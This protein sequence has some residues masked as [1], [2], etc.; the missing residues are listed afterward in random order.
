MNVF[1]TEFYEESR[2]YLL[3][4][5]S[6]V[7]DNYRSSERQIHDK[8]TPK[9]DRTQIRLGNIQIEARIDKRAFNKLLPKQRIVFYFLIRLAEFEE[10][11]SYVQVE[12]RDSWKELLEK[13]LSGSDIVF[14][15]SNLH[16]YFL[17]EYFQSIY[18]SISKQR[19]FFSTLVGKNKEKKELSLLEKLSKDSFAFK[20]EI[21]VPKKPKKPQF[22]K[23]YRD[24]GS[25]GSELSRIRREERDDIYLRKSYELEEKAHRD[26]IAFL[27]GFLE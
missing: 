26:T 6:A 24:H 4:L 13:K 14:T 1:S 23:G 19:I 7:E 25:L 22:R 17:L 27:E 21:V 16:G 3:Q 2:K 8:L 9:Q 15:M 11:L 20:F 10:N 12:W 5:L 18:S